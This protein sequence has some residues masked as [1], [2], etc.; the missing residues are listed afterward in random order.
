MTDAPKD[1]L[2]E[3]NKVLDKA[4]EMLNAETQK[5]SK[6]ALAIHDVDGELMVAIDAENK[7]MVYGKKY[8]PDH[9]AEVF[10]DAILSRYNKINLSKAR[11]LL[12]ETL[13]TEEGTPMD[14][15]DGLVEIAV[16]LGANR[17]QVTHLGE[18]KKERLRCFNTPTAD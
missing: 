7:T 18:Q 11:Q 3:A 8:E 9:A 14:M 13:G 2:Q 6:Y 4:Q 1:T 15:V 5:A 10:W 16:Q 17:D 12:T